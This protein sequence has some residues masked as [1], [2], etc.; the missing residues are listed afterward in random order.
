MGL[1]RGRWSISRFR[2]SKKSSW[3]SCKHG[4]F[5]LTLTDRKKNL[6]KIYLR[7]RSKV[8]QSRRQDDLEK[9]S[10][11]T[12][13]T[14]NNTLNNTLSGSLHFKK[15]SQHNPTQSINNPQVGHLP[16]LIKNVKLVKKNPLHDNSNFESKKESEK[17][18][19]SYIVGGSKK[20][21]SRNNLNLT[22]KSVGF[23]EKRWDIK[24]SLIR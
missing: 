23:R 19:T 22:K 3:K 21:S 6:K 12:L 16:R 2:Y 4:P 1:W 10:V 11:Q 15:A 17:E 13:S 18:R 20:L 8:F 9:G 14:L 7:L 24:I 5:N